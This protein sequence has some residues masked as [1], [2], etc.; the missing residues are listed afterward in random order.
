[1][2][3]GP[4]ALTDLLTA[5]RK[6]AGSASGDTALT[7]CAVS[8]GTPERL[9]ADRAAFD[10]VRN[11]L[12]SSTAQGWA[13]FRSAAYVTGRNKPLPDFDAAGEPL[14][15]E[16]RLDEA[17]SMRLTADP[18]G[19]GL[20]L[21]TYADRILA[22]GDP[23]PDGYRAALRQ[24]VTVLSDPIP[25]DPRTLGGKQEVLIHHV[26]WGASPEDPSAIR[27]LFDRFAGFDRTDRVLDKDHSR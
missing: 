15:A 16:W 9:T 6:I 11:A 10:R 23:I 7:L 19:S 22:P 12:A 20:V 25:E 17:S 14:R 3:S 8:S 26:Y 13:R 21:R 2:T 24:T 1:M 5:Y 4:K 18:G 27:R